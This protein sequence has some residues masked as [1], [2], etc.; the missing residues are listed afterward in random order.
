[1]VKDWT[2]SECLVEK[3]DRYEGYTSKCRQRRA[4]LSLA[5]KCHCQR[6]VALFIIEICHSSDFLCN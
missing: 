2:N 6:Y 5:N 4:T 3:G 1:M